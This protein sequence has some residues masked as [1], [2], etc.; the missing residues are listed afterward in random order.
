MGHC[1]AVVVGALPLLA[2][3]AAQAADAPQNIVH[4]RVAL[5]YDP[6]ARCPDIRPATEDDNPVVVV[7]FRVGTTGVP[8]Q[9]SVSTASGS[10]ELDAAAVSCVLKL[11][12]QPATRPGDAE[13]IESW[14]EMSWKQAPVHR[15]ARSGA[16]SAA[17]ATGTAAPAAAAAPVIAAAAAPV[18]AVSREP[19]AAPP[20]AGALTGAKIQMCLDGA[21]KLA[22]EPVLVHSS[23]NAEFDAAALRIAKAG[24]GAYRSANGRAG[25]ACVQLTLEAQ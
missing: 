22:Q 10:A 4:A 12:F 13:A 8:S 17:A 2:A 23:G 16:A 24:S 21:G 15:D 20:P 18:A 5:R 25:P 6:V 9:A 14:Q 11:R 19:A 7:R 1:S 3:V